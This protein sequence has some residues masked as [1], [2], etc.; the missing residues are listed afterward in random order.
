MYAVIIV[1][2]ALR[3]LS[4]I[5]TRDARRIDKTIL[6]LGTTPRPHGCMKL[7][8]SVDRW[9]IRIGD[10]RILY[11]ISDERKRIEVYRILHRKDVY[12]I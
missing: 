8:G 4:R 3:E 2:V 11:T 10:Y 12:R 6:T 1:D 7:A 9:R 5:P